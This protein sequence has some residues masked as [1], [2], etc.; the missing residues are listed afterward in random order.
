MNG[1]VVCYIERTP[2]GVGIR[3]LRLIAAGLSRTWTAPE[4]RDAGSGGLDTR[5]GGGG[6]AGIPRTGAAWITET[7]AGVGLKRLAAVCVDNEGSI[8]AWLSAPSPDP[9]IIQATVA[10]SSMDHEGGGSGAGVGAARLLAMTDGSAGSTGVTTGLGEA[11]LQ[12][13]ATIDP[14]E[15]G[16]GSSRFG[17][18]RRKATPSVTAR[19]R[20]A[21]LAVPDAPVRVLLDELDAKGIEVDRVMSVW[22][23]LAMAWDGAHAPAARGRGAIE[24]DAVPAA[25]IAVEHS[26]G[27]GRLVWAWTRSGEL[28]AGGSMRLSNVVQRPTEPAAPIAPLEST[29]LAT[30]EIGTQARRVS[31]EVESTPSIEFTTEDAGRLAMDWLAWS[32]QLGHCPRRVV[33]LSV[34]TLQA[35]GRGPQGLLAM[36][37]RAWPG[38]TIDGA[39]HD[40]PVGATLGRLAGLGNDAEAASL[41]TAQADA[42]PLPLSARPREALIGLSTRPGRA[43]RR[44]YQWI[45]AAMVGASAL[46]AALGYQV[47]RSLGDAQ[48]RLVAAKNEYQ[49]IIRGTEKFA[50]NII[51]EP[52]KEEALEDA[53]RRMREQMKTIKPPRPVLEE[54]VRLMEAMSKVAID[55]ATG[56]ETPRPQ[57]SEIDFSFMA[58]K[59]VLQVPDAQ[60]GP[61]VLENLLGTAGVLTWQGSSSG[62]GGSRTYLLLATWPEDLSVRPPARPMPN[63]TG[64][65]ATP[66]KPPSGAKTADA[67]SPAGA[68]GGEP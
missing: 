47:Y 11:S 40:D 31:E 25:T 28:V 32:A 5:V 48:S 63:S 51:A 27:G 53:L 52:K 13:L 50:P 2:G 67:S 39:I 54:T 21:V 6:A 58:A 30:P 35:G 44:M 46:V 34:P 36:L 62:S 16:G 41:P 19:N 4:A 65:S 24:S 49:E 12:A 64:Q 23:A 18:Q 26:P 9:R 10:S 29:D 33:C 3:R 45:G 61:T 60:T 43:D 22:H 15:Q 56:T 57:L 37:G 7:L 42:S 20:Y 14:A 68:E 55:P 1:G 66:A 59:A 38:A 17:L 8:C